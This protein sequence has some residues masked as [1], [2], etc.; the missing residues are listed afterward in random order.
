[1]SATPYPP[2]L[3]WLDPVGWIAAAPVA[4]VAEAWVGEEV[5]VDA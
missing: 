2:P 4:G 1:M 5:V 3:G